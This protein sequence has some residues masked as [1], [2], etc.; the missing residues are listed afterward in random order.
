MPSAGQIRIATEKVESEVIA[1]S[2]GSITIATN[3]LRPRNFA[4]VEFYSDAEGTTSVTPTAGN[5]TFTAELSV[6][7]EVFQDITG[8]T[9]TATS[10]ASVNFAGNP[11]RVRATFSGITGA[12]FAR[13]RVTQNY[14]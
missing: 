7:P 4:G 5:I 14:S 11:T 6:L 3:D 1:V 12:D 9:V 8:G 2:V 13:L 10:N